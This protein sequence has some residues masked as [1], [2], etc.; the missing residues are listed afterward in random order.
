MSVAWS[1]AGSRSPLAQTGLPTGGFGAFWTRKTL[2]CVGAD[3]GSYHIGPKPTWPL[4]TRSPI[5]TYPWQK[6]S[7]RRVSNP[8][9]VNVA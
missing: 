5:K 2:V 4:A 9:T 3:E 7:S 1:S 6:E 8:S